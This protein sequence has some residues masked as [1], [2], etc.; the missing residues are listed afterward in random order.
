MALRER[1]SNNGISPFWGLDFEEING[2]EM[3]GRMFSAP[4][5]HQ[6]VT[7]AAVLKVREMHSPEGGVTTP[8]SGSSSLFSANL[9]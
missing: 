4:G 3:A 8:A 1:K 9:P 6:G 7:E 2:L 5:G